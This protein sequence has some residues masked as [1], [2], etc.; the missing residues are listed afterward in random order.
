MDKVVELNQAVQD[1]KNGDTIMIGGF[2]GNGAPEVLIEAL[3]EKGIKDIT[4]ISTDTAIETRG[5]GKLI[6]D[7]RIK[8]L[9]ASHI[10]TNRE[11]GNQ[12]NQGVLEVELVP[13][14]TL[15]ERIR[16]AGF[17]LGGFL[18]KTGVG[19]RVEEGKEKLTIDGEDYL[20]ELPL[21]ADFALVQAAKADKNG[22]LVY[23][24][25]T[26]NFNH[27]MAAAAKTTIVEAKE[28]VDNGE[29]DPNLIV[30]PGVFVDRI[31]SRRGLNG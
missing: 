7:Y 28:V 13:Q 25:S 8:K 22:N 17:G 31:V 9:Y 14:G 11:T 4:L 29:L 19:T 24:G 18:T 12:M 20:L 10:G 16:S 21:E 23:K 26:I 2:M 27:V 15:A 3:L 30:T 5:S 6:S 1:I